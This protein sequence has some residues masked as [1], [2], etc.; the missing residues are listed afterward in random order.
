MLYS[1]A[2]CIEQP[3]ALLCICDVIVPC[4]LA[5]SDYKLDTSLYFIITNF[6]MEIKPQVQ[7][8]YEMN[9]LTLI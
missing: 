3:A 9:L 4:V 1:F 5:V 2:R 7:V 6:P 8:S